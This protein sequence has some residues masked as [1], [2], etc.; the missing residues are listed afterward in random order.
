MKERLPHPFRFRPK[1]LIWS[2]PIKPFEAPQCLNKLVYNNMNLKVYLNAILE[3][4]LLEAQSLG[5]RTCDMK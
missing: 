5:V 4:V 3:F 1:C 2:D